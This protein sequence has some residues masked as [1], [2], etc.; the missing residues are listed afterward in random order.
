MLNFADSEYKWCPQ[1]A[2]N[3]RLKAT[4]CRF[5]H[6][7]IEN[8]LMKKVALPSFVA[9][10]S[11][12]EWL[13]NFADVKAKLPAE[14]LSRLEQAESEIPEAQVPESIKNQLQPS[15]EIDCP[16][17]PPAANIQAVLM[18]LLL[19]I[20]SSGAPIAEIC[21]QPQLRLLE[22][23]PPEVV[24]EYELRMEE[25]DKG[26]RCT[27]CQ[28]FILADGDEC[29]FCQGTDQTPPKPIENTWE[30]PVDPLLL[31]DVIL[32]E[33]ARRASLEEEAIPQDILAA[34][35]ISQDDVDREI[36]RLRTGE[37]ELPMPRFTKRMVEL[38]LKCFWSPEQ[39]ALSAIADLGSALDSRKVNR[40]AEALVV[41]EHALRRTEGDDEL[42]S[43]RSTVLSKLSTHYLAKKDDSKYE[44][45]SAM[46]H[47]CGKFG[48]SDEM[49]TMM[50]KSHESMKNMFRGDS[51]FDTD[52]E[53]RLAS[54]DNDFG[55]NLSGM[56]DMLAQI[57]ETLPGMGEMLSSLQSGLAETMKNTRLI[58]EAQVAEKNGDLITAEAKYRQS[59]ANNNEDRLTGHL[60]KI[61][62]MTALG[63]IKHKQGENEESESLLKEAMAIALEYAEAV[64]TI[65]KASLYPV[66]N[67]Y[68][69]FLRDVGRHEESEQE[70]QKALQLEAEVSSTYLSEYGGSPGD[71]SGQR[72]DIKESYAQLLRAMKREEDAH[73]LDSEVAVLRKEA[74]DRQIEIEQRRAGRQ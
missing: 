6:K 45:Y 35:S 61:S 27:Y 33:A 56:G 74:A 62:S 40:S 4:H 28:E 52:P 15:V 53:K 18:D 12:K 65:G 70:F 72:A 59:L 38:K 31:K 23:T 17:E 24:A 10:R 42:M 66:L 11:I 37:A 41:L 44:L 16:H 58:L 13:P 69:C 46:S 49:K 47:E 5:C 34:S 51:H 50:D 64:P 21:E 29:C 36:L 3:I 67:V 25:M 55:L 14:F 2:G 32:Y 22:I 73:K 57:E 19:S 8:R 68:A 43:Q 30:K 63:Q 39:N 26:H 54:L 1:C 20:H 7:P 48:M 60:S 71:Y 9:V